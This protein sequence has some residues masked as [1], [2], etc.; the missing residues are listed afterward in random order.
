MVDMES[1]SNVDQQPT[2]GQGLAQHAGVPAK[3]AAF[4]TSLAE[5]L[6][7]HVPT[8]DVSDSSGRAERDAYVGL[9]TEYTA[10]A[11]R[12]DATAKQMSRYRDL[13]AA[14]HDPEALSDPRILE[15]FESFVTIESE[16]AELIRGSADR[17][18]EALR[19]FRGEE[20]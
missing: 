11:A 20:R 4:L 9:T 16:L 5:N 14:G 12:L 7:A 19:S 17:D 10:I 13:A 3:I 8:I 2:C 6:D 15:L 18:R 1:A